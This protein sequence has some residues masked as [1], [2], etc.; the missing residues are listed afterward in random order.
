MKA[1]IVEDDFVCRLLLQEILN[2]YGEI[3]VAVDGK[4][5][6]EAC[7]L[8]WQK[9]KPY[10]LICLD[11]MMPGMDG[12]TVLKEIRKKEAER[13]IHGLDGV[14]IFMTTAL[15]DKKNIMKSFKSQ[16]EVYLVKPIDGSKLLE[17]IRAFDLID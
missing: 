17:H 3:H 7:D 4:E 12:Q 5:A 2:P 13:N 15:K 16:C 8:A 9:E 10:D 11:I 6:L 1:L 14:K